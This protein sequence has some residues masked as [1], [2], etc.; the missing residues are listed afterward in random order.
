MLS[1]S[2]CLASCLANGD[3]ADRLFE[4]ICHLLDENM[5][6][7]APDEL[8]FDEADKA[9]L[10]F[11][12]ALLEQCHVQPHQ[13]GAQKRRKEADELLSFFGVPW[14][15]RHGI[16]HV[17]PAGCCGGAWE[18]PKANKAR[19]LARAKELVKF[20]FMPPVTEPAANKYTKT[21]PCVRAICLITWTFG[22]LR[23]AIGQ[24]LR[25]KG[26]CAGPADVVEADGAIG[27]PRDT[28]AYE[29]NSDI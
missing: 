23:K 17:C 14:S 29:K 16:C 24:M 28:Y 27:V 11:Q 4:A 15:G 5:L 9:E 3:V 25:K 12:E 20:I 22:L 2:F 10:A 8:E 18:G 13:D 6:I 26:E 1:P 21:D 19:S 7:I